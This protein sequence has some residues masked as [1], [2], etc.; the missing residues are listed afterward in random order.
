MNQQNPAED[1]ELVASNPISR[2]PTA[3]VSINLQYQNME[4]RQITEI[5][6]LE[7]FLRNNGIISGCLIIK[8]RYQ[9]EN[10]DIVQLHGPKEP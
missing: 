6:D 9:K 3:I 5:Q 4:P 10:G 1:L 2:Q 8:S 7:S